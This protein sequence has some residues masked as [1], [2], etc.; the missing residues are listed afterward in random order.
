MINKNK[1]SNVYDYKLKKL[2]LQELVLVCLEIIGISI[3]TIYVF[4]STE[5]AIDEEFYFVNITPSMIEL[6]VFMLSIILALINSGKTRKKKNI[7]K[8]YLNALKDDLSTELK[9]NY[10]SKADEVITN[11]DVYKEKLKKGE[12]ISFHNKREVIRSLIFSI[13]I[14][15]TV[16]VALFILFVANLNFPILIACELLIIY[17][18]VMIEFL[19]FQILINK[20]NS[21]VF[22]EKHKSVISTDKKF[23]RMEDMKYL[24]KVLFERWDRYRNYLTTFHVMAIVLNVLSIIITIIITGNNDRIRIWFG[25]ENSS[26]IVP[27]IFAIMTITLYLFDFIFGNE[28]NKK[29][30]EMDTYIS[31]SYTKE[32]YRSLKNS[33]KNILSYK[34]IFDSKALDIARGTYEYNIEVIED[35]RDRTI[36]YRYVFTLKHRIINNIPRV[37]LTAL[38]TFL[39]TGSILVWAKMQM[40][41]IVYVCLITVIVFMFSFLGMLLFDNI[42]Y[43]YW[44]QYC[45]MINSKNR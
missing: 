13:G 11:L 1:D 33:F 34:C 42:K 23:H 37:K 26:N 24:Q 29:I 3:C 21:N 20:S 16:S 40:Q 7:I 25:F 6:F 44:V 38:V 30:N 8:C 14:I 39:C 28:M 36:N 27:K 31:L 5:I 18:F 9:N 19:S 4:L 41:N 12:K 43:K 2:R 10:K 17:I 32:N 45:K 22:T 35:N 15:I